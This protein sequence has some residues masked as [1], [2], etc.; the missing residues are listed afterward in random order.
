MSEEDICDYITIQQDDK[1]TK[2]VRESTG[3]SSLLQG[4]ETRD[5]SKIENEDENVKT[6]C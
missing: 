5:G 4:C 1:M 6:K 3:V 2:S